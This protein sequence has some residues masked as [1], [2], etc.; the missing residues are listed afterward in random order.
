MALREA[1]ASFM[2]D[3]EGAIQNAEHRN[4]F[5]RKLKEIKRLKHHGVYTPNDAKRKIHFY[6]EA[7]SKGMR[8]S[9][10]DISYETGHWRPDPMSDETENS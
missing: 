8:P 9:I 7:Y 4:E 5:N 3:I 10:A 6:T 1:L 2:N